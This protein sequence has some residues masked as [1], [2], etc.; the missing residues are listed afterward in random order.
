MRA[1]YDS[2]QARGPPGAAKTAATS[3]APST[4]DEVLYS[5]PEAHGAHNY[6]DLPSKMEKISHPDRAPELD[7]EV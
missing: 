1:G 4:C 2:K 6:E 5:V 7:W 3:P